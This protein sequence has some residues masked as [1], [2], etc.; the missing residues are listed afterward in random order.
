MSGGAF[1]LVIAA[2]AA[3]PEYGYRGEEDLAPFMLI[4]SAIGFA[5]VV[6]AW[7]VRAGLAWIA[8]TAAPQSARVTAYH[9]VTGGRGRMKV[10]TSSAFLEITSGATGKARYQRVMWDP[11]LNQ[12]PQEFAVQVRVRGWGRLRRAVV[13]LPG[14][15]IWPA[16]RLRRRTPRFAFLTSRDPSESKPPRPQLI[17]I[18]LAAFVGIQLGLNGLAGPLGVLANV[19]LAIAGVIF[20]WAWTGGD[21]ITEDLQNR[22]ASN[23]RPVWLT[24]IAVPDTRPYRQRNGGRGRRRRGRSGTGRRRR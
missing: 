13:D 12:I 7:A 22:E 14:G 18:L 23:Q 9:S 3:G 10:Y 11:V 1:L 8:A 20:W 4:A 21:A 5:C 17:F 16:G 19:G 2:V 24:R 15:R 6:L